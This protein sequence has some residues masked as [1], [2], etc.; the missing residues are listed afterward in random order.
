MVE[1]KERGGAAVSRG[2]ITQIPDLGAKRSLERHGEPCVVDTL[3]KARA[4]A[5]T[6]LFKPSPAISEREAGIGKH[7]GCCVVDARE[8]SGATALF[9]TF[10][11]IPDLGARNGFCMGRHGEPWRVDAMVVAERRPYEGRLPRPAG[12]ERERGLERHEER[13]E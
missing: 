5:L 12:P 3:K 6:G 4:A 7:E 8:R 13:C 9:G 2:S 10:T 1:E 11:L